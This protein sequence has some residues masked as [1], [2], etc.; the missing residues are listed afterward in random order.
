M[1]IK[2]YILLKNPFLGALLHDFKFSGYT[3]KR[4]FGM[5]ICEVSY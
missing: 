3:K 5:V 1:E 4:L 2:V